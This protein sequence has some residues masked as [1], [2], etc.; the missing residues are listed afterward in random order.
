MSKTTKTTIFMFSLLDYKAMEE[1]F[2]IMAAQGWMLDKIGT[3]TV[4]FKKINPQNLKFT[5]D[6][7]P[8]LTAFDSPH[9][10]DVK[11]YQELCEQSGW[12]FVTTANKFQIFYANSDENPIPI[13]TDS[14]VEEKIVRQSVFGIEFLVFLIC[15]PALLFSLGKRAIFKQQ[16]LRLLVIYLKGCYN[17]KVPCITVLLTQHR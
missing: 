3:W 10:Q 15:L 13:Q 7:F 9:S 12:H 4:R 16:V 17:G 1:Y 2:E 5:V 11:N 8:Y 6:L 14:S